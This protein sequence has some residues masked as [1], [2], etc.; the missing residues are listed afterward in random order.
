MVASTS[1]RQGQ[2]RHREEPPREHVEVEEPEDQVQHEH[3]DGEDAV[4]DLAEPV[5]HRSGQLAAHPPVALGAEDERQ[6]EERPGDGVQDDLDARLP[7]ARD[8]QQPRPADRGAG[9]R[10]D[11]DRED[12]ATGQVVAEPLEHV[13]AGVRGQ[14]G[15]DGGEG[16][17]DHEPRQVAG[18]PLRV[19]TL[20]ARDLR[21][22]DLPDDAGR[23]ST[24]APT[25]TR[26]SRSAC[27]AADHGEAEQRQHE[28]ERDLGAQ[29]PH[30]GQRAREQLV[31]VQLGEGQVA[32]PVHPVRIVVEGSTTKA[33]TTTTQ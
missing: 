16:E 19:V 15:R 22:I 6:H 7:G 21:P 25:R 27:A 1:V 10:E 33:T 13:I 24:P 11:G 14:A 29:A 9:D 5:R 23:Q 8:E 17:P 30:L 12:P 31:P 20:V 3:V 18:Q 28:V 26:F 32:D 2:R 4:G